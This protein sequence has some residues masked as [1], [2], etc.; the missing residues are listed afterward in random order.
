MMSRE[1]ED[2]TPRVPREPSVFSGG[3][4][5][6]AERLREAATGGASARSKSERGAAD[7]RGGGKHASV[8]PFISGI[9]LQ[10]LGDAVE[11]LTGP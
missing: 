3:L 9:P 7:A 5:L 6:R 8:S 11:G 1:C 2:N 4:Y 10:R